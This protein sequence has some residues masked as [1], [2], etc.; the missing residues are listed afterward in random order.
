MIAVTI[1]LRMKIIANVTSTA[2]SVENESD[3]AYI[4]SLPRPFFFL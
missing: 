3:P 2:A 1:K 4:V